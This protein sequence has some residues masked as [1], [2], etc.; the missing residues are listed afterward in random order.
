KAVSTTSPPVPASTPGNYIV[1]YEFNVINTGTEVLNNLSVTDDLST[2]LGSVFQGV[3]PGSVTV[4]PGTATMAPIANPIYDGTASND[5]LL[6]GAAS[7]ALE[8]GQSFSISVAVEIDPDA[9]GAPDPATNQAIAMATDPNDEPVLD[10]SD[11]GIDPEGTNGEGGFEDPTPLPPLPSIMVSKDV[12][13][14]VEA[15]SGTGGN[16][17]VTFSYITKNTGNVNLS[18]VTLIDDMLLQFGAMGY[19]G[20]VPGSVAVN[21]ITA[22]Y[23]PDPNVLFDGIGGSEDDLLDDMSMD[24]L[25]PSEMFEVL[26]TVEIDP[27]EALMPLTNQAEVSGI[28]VDESGMVLINPLTGGLYTIGEIIDL[29]DDG[30][31]PTTDNGDGNFD[32]PTPVEIPAIGV[33]KMATVTQPALINGNYSVTYD[34][35]IENIGNTVLSSVGLEDDLASQLGGAFIQVLA[36]PTADVGAGNISY[37]GD[38]DDQLLDMTASLNPGDIINVQVIVE[39]DPD[40]PGAIYATGYILENSATAS[41]D[42]ILGDGTSGTVDD[43]SEDGTTSDGMDANNDGNNDT[44]TPLEIPSIGLAKEVAGIAEA[45]IQGNFVVSYNLIIQNTGN[46]VLDNVGLNDDLATQLGVPPYVSGSAMTTSIS[47]TGAMPGGLSG[48]YDGESMF[49]MLDGTAVLQPGEQILVGLELE[50]DASFVSDPPQENTATANGSYTLN[51]MTTGVVTDDSENGNNPDGSDVDGD[52]SGDTPT[53]LPPLPHIALAKNLSNVAQ[54][55]SGIPGNVDAT[56]TFEILND[57]TE[58]LIDISLIDNLLVELAPTYVSN[59]VPVIEVSSAT[60]DPAINTNYTG[61]IPFNDL[62]VGGGILEPGQTITVSVTVEV[63]PN[64]AGAPDPIANQGEVFGDYVDGNNIITVSDLS[65]SGVDPEGENPDAPGHGSGT[66]PYDDPTILEFPSIMITKELTEVTEAA[67]GIVGNFDITFGLLIENTG[68]VDLS[69]ITLEDDM[70]TQFGGTLVGVNT[71]PIFGPATSATSNPSFSAGFI[72]PVPSSDIFTGDDGLLEPGQFIEVIFTVEVDPDAV[73]VPSPLIENQAT[74]GG[75]SP[76][77]INA[78]DDSDS[79]TVPESTNPG[80]PGDTG[81]HDDPTPI[82]IPDIHVAKSLLD[83]AESASGVEGNV[84]ITLQYVVENTGNLNLNNLSL[85]DDLEVQ[86]G[87]AYAG[88]VTPPMIAASTAFMD[89]STNPGYTGSTGGTNM[90]DGMSGLLQPDE[91]ITVT[92]VVE[93][94]PNADG[95]PSP[96]VNQAT[97]SGDDPQGNTTDDL[98]DSGDE[99]EDNNP[100]EPGDTGGEDDPTLLRIPSISLAKTAIDAEFASSGMVGNFDVK[101]QLILKNTGNVD[102]D[103]IQVYDDLTADMM[104]AFVRIVPAA[105]L[106]LAANPYIVSSD[107][108]VDPVLSGGFDGMVPNDSI[109]DGISGLLPSNGEI[110]IEFIA[111]INPNANVP[112]DTLYNQATAEATGPGEDNFPVSDLSDSGTDPEGDNPDDIGDRGTSQDPT[113]LILSDINIA[114]HVS[115]QSIALSEFPGNV[116]VTFELIIKN[117]GNDTLTQ[118]QLMDDLQSQL[119]D[120]FIRLIPSSEL[121]SPNPEIIM[122]SASETPTLSNGYMGGS[123]NIFIGSDGKLGPNE[124][125]TVQVVAEV[126]PDAVDANMDGTPDTL[127]NQSIVMAVNPMGMTVMDASDSGTDPESNNPGADGDTGGM[128]D[129]TPLLSPVINAAKQVTGYQSPTSG[130]SG[131]L[132][133]FIEIVIKNTGNVPLDNISLFDTLSNDPLLGPAY[134]GIAPGGDPVIVS[135]TASVDPV[136]NPSFDGTDLNPNIFDGVSGI[137]NGC[138]SIRVAFIVEINPE[139]AIDPSELYNQAN[140]MGN[141]EGETVM[142]L[143]DSGTDPKSTNPDGEKDTGGH[144][145][146]TPIYPCLSNCEVEAKSLIHVSLDEMCMAEINASNI[147]IGIP[148][149]CDFYYTISIE[150]EH[151]NVLPSNKIDGSYL[152]QKLKVSITEPECGN[153]AWGYALVEDKLPPTII[154]EDVEISCVQAMTY[155]TPPAVEDNCWADIEMVNEVHEL[156]DCDDNYIGKIRREWIATDGYGNQSEVCE[157]TIWLLR[158]DLSGIMWPSSHTVLGNT[159]LECGSGYAE[160]GEGNPD[161]SVTGVPKLNGVDLYPFEANIICNG[162]VEYNDRVIQSTDCYTRIERVWTVGEWWCSD[163]NDQIHVQIIEI[164]DTQAPVITVCPSDITVSTDSRSCMATVELP[165][166]AFEDACDSPVKVNIIAEQGSLNDSNGGLIDLEAGLHTVTYVVTDK[167]GNSSTCDVDVLVV[168]EKPPVVI[169]EQDL[170]VSLGGSGNARLQ[171]I[172]LDLGSF[173]ECTKLTYEA[174][175]MTDACDISGTDWGEEIHFCC[176]DAGQIV[177]VLLKVTDKSGNSNECMVEV[178]VQDKLPPRMECIDDMTINCNA[179]YA[180]NNLTAS[181]GFPEIVADNCP[182]NNEIRESFIED[183]NQCGIGS[184]HRTFQLF[185]GNGVFIQEC[186]QW[187]TIKGDTDS[188]LFVIDWPDDF[189]TDDLCS[190]N[191]LHPDNLPVDNGWPIVPDDFCTL[192]GMD[193]SDEFYDAT[194]GDEACFKIIRTWKV[195]DWCNKDDGPNG[196]FIPKFEWEQVIKVN[197]TLSPTITG[198]CSDRV[199]ENLDTDCG[200]VRVQLSM[201]GMDDCTPPEDLLIRYE[202]DE[203]NDG[204]VDYTAVADEVDQFFPLGTHSI[205]WEVEDRCGNITSCE[206]EFETRNVKDPTPICIDGLSIDLQAM[207]MDGDLLAD[208][209][210]AILTPDM[211]DAKSSHPCANPITLSFSSDP[212]D[213]EMTFSCE[214]VGE[215]MV[216]LWVTDIYGNQAYCITRIQITANGD[217]GLCGD[218]GMV[219]INGRVSTM[220]DENIEAVEVTLMG[221]ELPSEMTGSDGEYAFNDMTTGGSYDVVPEKDDDPMNGVSTLDIVHIQRHILGIK[222]ITDPYLL[223]AGDVNGSGSITA[224]DIIELRKLILGHYDTFPN[225]TSWRFVDATY[226]YTDPLA[227]W[228][229]EAPQ[230]YRIPELISSMDIDFIGMKVGDISGDA[231]ANGREMNEGNRS[232]VSTWISLKDRYLLKGE[233]SI[234][235]VRSDEGADWKGLQMEMQLNGIEIAGLGSDHLEINEG[236]YRIDGDKL[237]LS[238]NDEAELVTEGSIFYVEVEAKESGYISEM[239]SLSEERLVSEV[240][241]GATAEVIPVE[242]RWEDASA[243]TFIVSQNIPNPWSELTRL[244]FSIPRDGEVKLIIRDVSGKQLKVIDDNYRAGN[245]SI[246]IRGDEIRA[247]GVLL[248]EVYYGG[249]RISGRMI[250]VK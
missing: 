31:D 138:D 140:A 184:I 195:I 192:M 134:V 190:G 160:D 19:V 143:T 193:Y 26:V 235:E 179:T 61:L 6:S 167:C 135:T 177:M 45:N 105:E 156:I 203:D 231:S 62:F 209:V 116:D 194:T 75:D 44:P 219:S 228:D 100:G 132:D 58:T 67:S 165:P 141:Y 242:I 48:T 232:E 15:S 245:N 86:F 97:A 8:P 46:T 79:G 119:G 243:G 244:D 248:Y 240:Y 4:L 112:V 107:A 129:P 130:I 5:D 109:F 157:Q 246:Q 161:P 201:S 142:D 164:D 50:V 51:D 216:E 233:T 212:T 33:A 59:E 120:Q 239:I 110:V 145:D 95:G 238:I 72:G 124:L 213:Q 197:N 128:N 53:P 114:K 214:D 163:V 37:N 111:E 64:A 205:R 108:S 210:M 84:D 78:E 127:F 87:P 215:N 158:T 208:T 188:D 106:G 153:T 39:I 68:N 249:E 55:S 137:L 151:G 159:A 152:G 225:N 196:T 118:L 169:C 73:G 224:T 180:M 155:D 181:F 171:A 80:A 76:S 218:G 230:S 57:G 113:P 189:T 17:D 23:P 139:L 102:L 92:V 7:D 96:L 234:I 3:I 115:N 82:P 36:A 166:I 47:G 94:D 250:K 172:D 91:Q 220:Y 170:V 168:D 207:D 42:F 25:K 83:V 16:Y 176:E 81:G 202:I 1:T 41:G 229:E 150:D 211:I 85:E 186:E 71:P 27:S 187:I 54:A 133:V 198:D 69:S 178:R 98:S 43:Q 14:V 20:V 29:S 30:T 11:N 131:H 237:I 175:R 63:D 9:P 206:Y 226:E 32:T 13:N 89:P 146:P 35:I 173:D 28:P 10:L 49:E 136:I 101:Y 122:S 104:S 200:D 34:Y 38:A 199:F 52:M 247:T 227:P 2:Q 103:S 147:G 236:H 221:S 22:S 24:T 123:E 121:G 126:D 93:V 117:K 204:D 241:V 12:I 66:N 217:Q 70:V 182:Q 21:N 223:V 149:Y 222:E 183:V 90:L 99:P 154:C 65:D 56:F 125:I 144:N 174:R 191:D 148:L 185:D 88:V 77:G 74:A 18:D 40:N 60:M 162:F